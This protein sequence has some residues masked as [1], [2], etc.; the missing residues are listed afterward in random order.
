MK[1]LHRRNRL[2]SSSTVMPTIVV[3]ESASQAI[4]NA[5]TAV[6]PEDFCS[7]KHSAI[8]YHAIVTYGL[9]KPF[10]SPAP[11]FLFFPLYRRMLWVLAFDPVP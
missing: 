10:A 1:L 2:S 3:S 5:V 4:S 9:T 6:A 7:G 8:F 11:I